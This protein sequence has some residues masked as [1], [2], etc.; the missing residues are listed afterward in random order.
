MQG[1]I[2]VAIGMI[3]VF[4]LLSV[5]VTTLNSVITN[6][7]QWRAK[8]LKAAI[9]TLITDQSIQ[10]LFLQ[11]PLINIVNPNAP[12]TPKEQAQA[13]SAST[14]P[15]AMALGKRDPT[16]NQVS[17]IDAKT[18]SQ[19]LSSILAEKSAI[20]LYGPLDAAISALPDSP[21][22]QHLRD[23]FYGLQNTGTG[24]NDVRA[25]V[26]ALPAEQQTSI[27][28]PLKVLE[29]RGAAAQ[30]ASSDGS[31]L[32][33]VL[34]GL[35]QVNDGAFKTA[36]QV[37]VSSAQTVDQAQAN[38]GTWFDQ[39]MDQLSEAYKHNLTLLTLGIGLVLALLL[40]AD[41]LQLARSLWED[42]TLRDSVSQVVQATS[43]QI[44]Q[45]AAQAAQEQQNLL[46]ATPVPGNAAAESATGTSISA[47]A[48]AQSASQITN[49]LTQLTSL[50]LPIGW[51][52]TPV[53]GGCFINT[54]AN[55]PAVTATPEGLSPTATALPPTATATEISLS[56]TETV[57]PTETASTGQTPVIGAAQQVIVP[58]ECASQRNLWLLLPG[59][60]PDWFGSILRKLIGFAVTVIAI[61]Q[62]APFWFDLIRRLVNPSSG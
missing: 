49:T 54:D 35:R 48:V 19:V 34:D 46:T 20:V 18:F 45:Q 32:L 26:L 1:I 30:L 13:A 57:T 11:H 28:T 44:A 23:I 41:S 37:I 4:S 38:I 33:P 61:G 29:D 50:N 43:A 40:N 56:V 7:L 60:S 62:G 10:Q 58:A 52:F 2:Q 55:K 9:E 25:A 27:L 36:L 15:G 8:H 14:D 5:L 21:A 22:K 47:Q 24:L 16:I 12:T 53:E 51:E 17:Y 3:F 31:R 6:V 39:R 42:P 59:N